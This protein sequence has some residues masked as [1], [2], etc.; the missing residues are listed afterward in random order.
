MLA[1]R[2][3]TAVVLLIS[4]LI[5]ELNNNTLLGMILLFAVTAAYVA[6]R[7]TGLLKD[8]AP[9]KL[10]AGVL[11]ALL[12]VGAFVISY[13]P[14]GRVPAAE[15]ISG[16]TGVIQLRDGK[17]RGVIDTDTG[18]EVYAGIP[19]AA[20]PVGELRWREPQDPEPWDGVLEADK[21]APMSMQPRNIPIYYSLADI[22]GYHERK[23]FDMTD[24]YRPEIS[25]DS[26]YVNVWKP[27]GD[28]KDLPVLVYVHGG[29]LQTGQPWFTDYS[30]KNLAKQGVVVVNMGYRLGVFGYLAVKELAD[31]SPNKTTGNYGLLDQIKALQ[32]VKENIRAF[33]G[34][35]DNVTLAGESAGAA[36]VSALCT[37]PLAKGLFRRAVI[38]SSTVASETPPHSYR[39]FEDA[40]ASGGELMKKY[41][42]GSVAELRALPAEKLVASADT[43]HHITPDGYVLTED[44]C[45]S[46]KKGVHNEEAALHGFNKRESGVF[47]LFTKTGM[48]NYESK[49]RA[50][51]GDLAPEVLKSYPAKN[52]EEA[53]EYWAEIYGAT[54]FDYPHYCYNRL[55]KENG[56]PVYEYYFTKENGRTGSW[57]GGEQIYLYGNIP[58]NSKLFDENDRRIMDIFSSYMLNFIKNGDPNGEGLPEFAQNDDSVS[59]LEIG[60]DVAPVKEKDRKLELFAILDKLNKK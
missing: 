14:V 41:N 25:E 39:S 38:E 51:F 60:E 10:G 29:S 28:V 30:G 23:W 58:E 5:F 42:A 37:S 18:T 33:G 32:W 19:Y 59:Y 15:K 43:E 20:P 48:K 1:Y 46:Y 12:I 9:L 35:P 54:F 47:I 17:V 3:V 50:Y 4:L 36:S 7:E 53:A 31:E 22:I 55:A 21:F 8:S 26:L 34:D 11:F 45:V 6:V 52:D 16:R 49:I 13:P 24:N 27:Q 44:P 40:L 2:I 56:I 57:H